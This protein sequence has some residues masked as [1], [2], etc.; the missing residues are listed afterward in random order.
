MKNIRKIRFL[1]LWFPWRRRDALIG[2]LW[3]VVSQSGAVDDEEL[4]DIGEMFATY[5][6]AGKG[7]SH[8]TNSRSNL[9]R[10]SPFSVRPSSLI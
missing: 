7:G 6:G 10:L 8:K 5:S 4:E 9:N 2:R 1:D 3:C